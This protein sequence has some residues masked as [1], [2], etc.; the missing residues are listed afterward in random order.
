VLIT[1]ENLARYTKES[2]AHHPIHPTKSRRKVSWR[3]VCNEKMCV[4]VCVCVC[5]CGCE[6]ARKRV[7]EG[8]A[9][10]EK[11]E[12]VCSMEAEWLSQPNPTVTEKK[13]KKKKNSNTTP[14][15]KSASRLNVLFMG[16]PGPFLGSS[17]RP[18]CAAGTRFYLS[19]SLW[20]LSPTTGTKARPT[21]R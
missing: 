2:T 1:S 21:K 7:M 11:R 20:S 15:P 8:R 10:E 17:S 19:L 12:R 16:V 4:C 18:P 3:S 14:S 13:K 6:E 5:V 9:K